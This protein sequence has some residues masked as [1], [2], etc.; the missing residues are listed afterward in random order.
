MARPNPGVDGAD[1]RILH[2]LQLDG[3]LSNKVL[4]ERTHISESACLRHRHR[5]EATGLI[6][7]Y[8]AVIDQTLA[9]FPDTVFVDVS[10]RSQQEAHLAAFER[11]LREIPEVMECYSVS[12]GVDYRLRVIAVDSQ[13]FERT[14]ARLAQ[15]PDVDQ[16]HSNFALRAVIKKTELPLAADVNVR[17]STR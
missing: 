17:G 15:L 5:L 10:L 4:A 16:L 12:G 14:R 11:A 3:R 6:A 13:H 8:V 9:G 2:E 1:R 7:G